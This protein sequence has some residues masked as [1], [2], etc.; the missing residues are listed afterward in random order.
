MPGNAA[1]PVTSP[2]RKEGNKNMR[3]L[4]N[5]IY[6]HR[7]KLIIKDEQGIYVEGYLH[8]FPTFTDARYFID[9]MHS[10]CHKREPAIIGKWKAPRTG[11]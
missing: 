10:G 2:G 7:N 11:D 5:G 6:I 9:K 8:I 4:G 3:K 1:S